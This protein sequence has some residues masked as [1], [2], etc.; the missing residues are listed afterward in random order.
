MVTLRKR[1]R[2]RTSMGLIVLA[3]LGMAFLRKTPD[4]G[5]VYR[6]K[7]ADPQGRMSAAVQLGMLGSKK[8]KFAEPALLAALSDPNQGVCDSAAWALNQFGS[9][10]PALVKALVKQVE[11]ETLQS[12]R[13]RW[14]GDFYMRVDPVEALTRIKPPAS[15]LAPL[16]GK[17]MT[18]PDPWIR[19]RAAKLLRDAIQ[20][21]GA[22]DSERVS[23]SPD[24][25]PGQ[26]VEPPPPV[27]RRACEARRRDPAKGGRHPP[28]AASK[29]RSRGCSRSHRRA[30]QVRPGGGTGRQDPRRSATK[31]RPGG[32]PRDALLARQARSRGEAGR[33]GDPAGHDGERRR[34]EQA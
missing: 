7:H 1:W 19:L 32:S 21:S 10:S 3:A 27:R 31:G 26:G 24:G 5:P 29:P 20:W 16:L 15:T 9:T 6:L 11:V 4:L 14:Q 30:R 2:L 13:W 34:K 18:N 23:A 22:S 28:A 17:A 12:L 25:A 8:G 33:S